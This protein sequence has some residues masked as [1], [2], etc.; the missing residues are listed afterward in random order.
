MTRKKP[1]GTIIQSGV[2]WSTEMSDDN[3]VDAVLHFLMP[4]INSMA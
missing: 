1:D 4:V 2:D 3:R